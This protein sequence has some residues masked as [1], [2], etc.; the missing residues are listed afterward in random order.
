MKKKITVAC[1]TTLLMPH[2]YQ[3]YGLLK[4]NSVAITTGSVVYSLRM[5]RLIKSHFKQFP[6]VLSLQWRHNNPMVSQITSLTIVYS[7]IYSGTD[8]SKHSELRVTGL[9]GGNSPVTGEFPAQRASN[10]ENVSIWWRH[11][12]VLRD[13]VWCKW[14]IQYQFSM[15]YS[16][17]HV[18]A[19]KDLCVVIRLHLDHHKPTWN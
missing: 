14:C 7:A 12:V 11:H 17:Q 10:G 13:W 19:E 16:T 8:Q 2:Y 3:Y 18:F 9:C 6:F 5:N 15:C 1:L 4:K